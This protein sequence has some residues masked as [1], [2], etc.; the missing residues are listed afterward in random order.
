MEVNA[1]ILELLIVLLGARLAGEAAARAGVPA[2]MGEMTAG[3]VLGPGMLGWIS[4]DHMLRLLAEIGLILLLFEVGL[5]TNIANLVRRGRASAVV[6]IA[7]FVAPL[8]LGFMLARH[9]FGQSVIVSLFIGGALTATSI[10]VTMRVMRD[11]ELHRSRAAEVVLGAAVI[12]DVL[13][14][15]LLALLFEFANG[16]ASLFNAAR[17]LLFVALFV[18]IAPVA[19]SLMTGLVCRFRAHAAIPGLI[20]TSAIVLVLFFAW[21]AH[22]VGAPALLGGFAAGLALS[23]HFR[24]PAP[25]SWRPDAAFLTDVEQDTKPVIHLFTPIF[26]VMVGASLNLRAV[27]WSSP[28]VWWMATTLLALALLT[29]LMGGFLIRAQRSEQWMIGVAM[30]PRAEVGLI[31]TELART[32]NVFDDDLYAVMI[33]VIA[34]TTVLP[35][36]LMKRLAASSG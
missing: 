7:G 14:V 13:G 10:G 34:G 30:I 18:A 21:L 15:V 26:F 31:F 2:M 28:T 24:L 5:D 36:L 16:G 11:L 20:P 1:F 3:I 29:K 17:I 23:P 25:P 12:D 35:P 6:A 19:A 4:A 9:G 27:D 33:L 8:A 22:A 32:A